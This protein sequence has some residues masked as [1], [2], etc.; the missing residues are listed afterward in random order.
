MMPSRNDPATPVS[1]RVQ[2]RMSPIE[3]RSGADG[4]LAH[5]L[6]GNTLVQ[7][8]TPVLRIALG[9]VLAAV[10]SRYLGAEGLGS[11]ALVFAY[12]ATFDGVFNEGGSERFC[13]GR[14]PGAPRSATGCSRVGRCCKW[15]WR[16]ARTL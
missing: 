11:Y 6:V 4:G 10:L 14:S 1:L 9:I 7:V 3:D 15:R 5:R 13:C 2:R 16:A 8:V 12:V